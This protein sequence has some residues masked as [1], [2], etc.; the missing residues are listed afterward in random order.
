M[1]LLDRVLPEP[2]F[3]VRDPQAV[4]RDMVAQYELLSGKTL[5]PAQIERLQID[6]A[7]Y[8]E[9]LMREALQDAAKLNLV[10]FSRAPILDFLGENV[11]VRRLLAVPAKTV[12]RLTFDPVPTGPVL[13]P[14]G[15]RVEG[16]SAVFLSEVPVQISA[17]QTQADVVAVCE[18]A[19]L[20]GNGFLPG[21]INALASAV[22]GVV[23][24]SVANITTSAGGAEDELD[25]QLRERIFLAPA[26]F[27]V[28]GP[29]D[30]YRFHALSGHPDVIDVAVRAPDLALDAGVLGSANDVPPGCVYLYPLT[31]VG[32]PSDAVK[33][34]V[35]AACNGDNKRPLGDFVQVFDP[36]VIDY[37]IVANIT[38]YDTADPASVMP[39]VTQA[40]QAYRDRISAKL[41][42]DV[43]RD[44]Q[45][46][47]L[48]V[49]GV[50][51]VGLVGADI[52]VVDHG[53]PRC[54]GISVTLVGTK[55]G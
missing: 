47:A 6:V 40:A 26:S 29:V 9:S 34:A 46:A 12:L 4:V 8:R 23:I 44:E 5:Y 7:A 35:L 48:K 52:E 37:S 21:Q 17:G 53:W 30:A 3:V 10:R 51:S 38:L 31:K 11:G 27:S 54:T 28:A 50:Y 1:S 14:A 41:G 22:G 15:L 33:A 39:A 45:I 36:V 13:I 16:G 24:A 20:V 19:G 25:D 32:L 43:I 2:V 49:P 55:K 18:Q 42:T